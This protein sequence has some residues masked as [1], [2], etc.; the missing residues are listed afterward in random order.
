MDPLNRTPATS[1]EQPQVPFTDLDFSNGVDTPEIQDDNYKRLFE[2]QRARTKLIQMTQDWSSIKKQAEVNRSMR[3]IEVDMEVMRSN[4]YLKP[5][6][7]LIPIHVIDENVRK[8]QPQF[9]Q[10]ILGSERE[11]VF[12]CIDNPTINTEQQEGD[13]TRGL[14]YAGHEIPKYKC[15]DGAQVHGWDTLMVEYDDSKPFKVGYHHVG[16]EKLM[17]N[18]TAKDIQ[19]EELIVLEHDCSVMQL[20]KFVNSNG[21]DATQVTHIERLFAEKD[22]KENIY[23]YQAMWKWNNTVYTAWSYIDRNCCTD[24]LKKPAKLW[25][26]LKEQ[27]PQITIATVADP[28]S[29]M[30]VQVPQTTMTWQDVYETDYPVEILFYEETEEEK[31]IEHRGRCFKDQSKQEAQTALWSMY[32]NGTNRASNVYGSSKQPNTTGTPPKRLELSL[33]PGCLYDSPMEF[34]NTPYPSPEILAA[35]DR[36]DVRTQAEQGR[37]A[38]S[39]INR[40]DARKTSAEIKSA[41]NE[42][43]KLASVDLML[44]QVF[45]RNM[46]TRVWRIVKSLAMQ[47]VIPFLMIWKDENTGLYVNDISKLQLQYDVRPAGDVDLI[48]RKQKQEARMAMLGPTQSI[49]PLY[50]AILMDLLKDALPQDYPKYVQIVQQFMQQQAMMA[51]QQQPQLPQA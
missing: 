45:W 41:S 34:W 30:T 25:L 43:E 17:F 37:I 38:E 49:P 15:L 3:K 13:Y 7:C 31:I 50:M 16:H 46:H 27:V 6:E 33:E 20:K 29:G 48:K 4:G 23:I 26:G 42:E 10:Y 40:Q 1:F 8:E 5:D 36:L 39:V 12:V 35:A 19:A 51:A 2:Y 47:G 24:W 32:I 44:Y 22:I 9:L 11:A 21:F 28:M 18:L 14:R